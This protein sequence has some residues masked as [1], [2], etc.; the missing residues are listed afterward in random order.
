MTIMR[1]DPF[2]DLVDLQERMN[3]LFEDSLRRFR[4]VDL[5]FSGGAFVPPVDIYETDNE[6]VLKAEIPG[7]KKEDIKIEVSD[8]VLTLKG[9]KKEEREIKEENYH[10]IERT[11]GSF[12]RSFTLPTNVDRDKIKATYKD[13][14]LEVVLPKKEEAKPREVRID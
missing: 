5:D 8:G 11:Y 12:Q 13:G 2:K 7:V 4:T 14:V 9:E 3:R 1:W 10:R 6:I